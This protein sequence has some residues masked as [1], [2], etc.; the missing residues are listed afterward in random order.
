MERASVCSITR[1]TFPDRQP[2]GWWTA[3]PPI[4]SRSPRACDERRWFAF[5]PAWALALRLRAS[6]AW[7]TSPYNDDHSLD[8]IPRLFGGFGATARPR[9]GL[10][11]GLLC[12]LR[13]GLSCHHFLRA[14]AWLWTT[15][16]VF[17]APPEP[18]NFRHSLPCVCSFGP[19]DHAITTA[20]PLSGDLPRRATT[21]VLA[22]I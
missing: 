10:C 6:W 18:L 20:S 3:H 15:L 22:S 11:F 12:R 13:I 5:H 1:P 19:A 21:S 14:L 7:R 2:K 17:R 9:D 16:M 4:S 8:Q